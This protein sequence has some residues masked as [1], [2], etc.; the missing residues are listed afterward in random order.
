MD[1]ELRLKATVADIR[2]SLDRL[3]NQYTN[4]Y[5]RLEKRLSSV[6]EELAKLTSSQVISNT[7]DK[8]VEQKH[9]ID[10]PWLST[11][12]DASKS[13]AAT[14]DNQ[15]VALPQKKEVEEIE[16]D[17][18]E[19]A[20]PVRSQIVLSQPE[21]QQEPGFI[22]LLLTKIFAF[23]GTMLFAIVST[24]AAPLKNL[25]YMG[26]NLFKHY[27][28][29]GQTA[30]FLMTIAG[31]ITLTAGFGYLLQYSFNHYFSDELKAI[32]GFVLG[33][34]I[35]AIGVLIARKKPEFDEYA[36]SVIALGVIFNFLTA[37]FVGPYFGMVSQITS[38]LLLF[39]VVAVS[40]YLSIAYQTKIVAVIT[41]IGGM[42][43]PFIMG[44]LSPFKGE[45]LIYILVLSAGNL[46]LSKKINWPTLSILTFALS[47][48]VIEYIGISAT[49]PSIAAMFIVSALFLMYGYHWSFN[50]KKLKDTV[51]GREVSLILA[52]AFYFIYSMMSIEGSDGL[53]STVLLVFSILLS[54][55]IFKL[56]IIS[57]T[58]A[59]IYVL[60]SG[61][62]FTGAV[63][64]LLP[65]ELIGL[66][67]SLEAL[68]IYYVGAYYKNKYIRAE[69][70]L[71]YVLSMIGAIPFAIK[72]IF[73]APPYGSMVSWV[74]ILLVGVFIYAAYKITTHFKEGLEKVEI[75]AGEIL[76][77]I[78]SL[79]GVLFTMYLFNVLTSNSTMALL[80]AIPLVW[81]LYR[82]AKHNLKYTQVLTY[83]LSLFFI[84]QFST[85]L[86]LQAKGHT[87][88]SLQSL[89]TLFSLAEFIV[90]SW[91]IHYFYKRY[92]IC[93]AGATLARVLNK[94][95]FYVPAVLLLASI[96]N[97][98]AFHIFYGFPLTFSEAWFD[99]FII[100]GVFVLW[101]KIASVSLYDDK[102]N[103][104]QRRRYF[105]KEA[106]SFYG[107]IFFIYTAAI[108]SLPWA[109]NMAM[110]SMLYL[111]HR[112]IKEKLP[113]TEKLAYVHFIFFGI[114]AFISHEIVGTWIFSEQ[115]LPAKV[116]W[117]QALVSAWLLKL[118]YERA[119]SKE[120]LFNV[121]SLIRVGVY[122]LIPVLFI[123][124][125][126]RLYTEYLPVALWGSFLV[127]WLMYKKLEIEALRIEL[128]ALFVIAAASTGYIVIS[129][130]AGYHQLEGILA[131]AAG[132]IAVIIVLLTEQAFNSIVSTQQGTNVKALSPYYKVFIFSPYYFV[133]AAL[134]LTYAFTNEV[135]LAV[136]AG[137]LL[138]YVLLTTPKVINIVKPTINIMF[139]IAIILL[140]ISPV[141]L[142]IKMSPASN[143]LLDLVSVLAS[144]SFLYLITHR[145][146]GVFYLLRRRIMTPDVYLWGFHIITLV[147]YVSV[148][149]MLISG[150]V[151]VT[152]AI[153]IHA[154]LVLFLTLNEEY[155]SLLK[156]SIG[157][158]T[159][160]AAKML[161][162]DMSDYE[163]M[164]KI[165]ALM[166][167]G[168]ILMG[169]A[170]LFQHMKSKKIEANI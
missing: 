166:C 97:I 44:D 125:I 77:E 141:T 4:E 138:A 54:V 145:M 157:L 169:S 98:S 80:A 148:I 45:F 146:I 108:V 95:V 48:G 41:V 11:N 168:S 22:A 60:I 144:L 86:D 142:F 14:S 131:L 18:E 106:F 121:A 28:H 21:A 137:G 126:K 132:S 74:S 103:T 149:N 6:E 7:P 104:A 91:L 30:V 118:F 152:I 61:A 25:W 116:A 115:T 165:I 29:K 110:L 162:N 105:M 36:A 31:I 133:F 75:S 82:V 88:L 47:L 52:N 62:L 111:L 8:I 119:E 67:L 69:G 59:P 33:F 78:F 87:V 2:Q 12:L 140:S 139:I 159:L 50:G 17:P 73:D 167:I 85:G 161:F 46:Y 76:N 32:S 136:L 58:L 49:R 113:V 19:K 160:T 55:A 156:L 134:S 107:V 68:S 23:I 153:L 1:N 158:Y 122:L 39:T 63:F 42:L 89:S 9:K 65:G 93:G 37:Y 90:F 150:G 163:T 114:T 92:D 112:S 101:Y 27:Q 64:V 51:N 102:V 123:P 117:I 120:G 40:F 5:S 135:R 57:N 15:P 66:V 71:L 154:V 84:Y 99:Y 83:V 124:H 53:V 130:I 94:G 128:T 129:A 147:A 155:K 164:H 13:A 109:G 34:I 20:A 35:I 170:Y 3:N 79:W 100:G 43:M 127:S 72:S 143:A 16:H 10:D 38:L 151:S 96:V 56:K 24:A 26:V 81:C 70:T